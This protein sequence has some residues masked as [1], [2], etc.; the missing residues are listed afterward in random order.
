MLW[1]ADYYIG[2]MGYHYTVFTLDPARR[3]HL[4][5]LGGLNEDLI[6]KGRSKGGHRLG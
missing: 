5:L 2:L 4:I 1:G 6:S 3:I